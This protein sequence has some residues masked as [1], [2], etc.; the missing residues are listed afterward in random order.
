[1]ADK[2]FREIKGILSD[3]D[4][5]LYNFSGIQEQALAE[6]ALLAASCLD[7]KK[8]EFLDA[9]QKGREEIKNK[10]TGKTA[11]LHS[12][13]LYCQ[14]ALELL[15]TNGLSCALELEQCYWDCVIRDM[16]A[17][18][19]VADFFRAAREKGSRTG[20][21]SDMTAA[22]QH[23][24]LRRLELIPYLDALVTS[25]ETG[26]EKPAPEMFNRCLEKMGVRAEQCLYIGDDVDKDVKGAIGVGLLPV[27]I[28]DEAE[29][30][31]IQKE[32]FLVTGSFKALER[33]IK[34]GT[35]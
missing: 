29:P 4:D 22:I 27:L 14:R 30:A 1:M 9:Y 7:V 25:E 20:I 24:K 6:T 13:L 16:K 34:N 8:E 12:R 23:R 15:G 5:T 18:S 35:E 19:G 32:G 3:L 21:C 17:K 11:A 28:Q 26:V 31:V 2:R 33:F 10:M